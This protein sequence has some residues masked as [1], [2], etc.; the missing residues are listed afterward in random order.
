M[1]S[2]RCVPPGSSVIV[3][4]QENRRAVSE[5]SRA[6]PARRLR[7]GPTSRSS[8][9]ASAAGSGSPACRVEARPAASRPPE[10]PGTATGRLTSAAATARLR[11]VRTFDSDDRL[12]VYAAHQIA[13][14]PNQHD[15][16]QRGP[17][18]DGGDASE[19]DRQRHRG[20]QSRRPA[21]ELVA[22]ADRQ[23]PDAHHEADDSRGSEL[24]DDA[25]A[26]GAEAELAGDLQEIGADQPERADQDPL[27]AVGHQRGR[28]QE[29]ER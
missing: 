25:V 26:H 18:G 9:F 3:S 5:Y 24:G 1:Y 4:W 16:D 27:L 6:S 12:L 20:A 21:G 28:Q 22:G 11:R 14:G 2:N 29:D 7:S 23:E 19:K 15:Q 17:D 8:R 13:D 10:P